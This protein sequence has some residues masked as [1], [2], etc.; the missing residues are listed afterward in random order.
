MEIEFVITPAGITEQPEAIA[1]TIL[2]QIGTDALLAVSAREI[3]PLE[4]GVAFQFGNRYGLKRYITVTY[5]PA[6]DDYEILATRIQRNGTVKQIAQYEGITWESL[7][8]LVRDI[9]N[10][11]EITRIL[12]REE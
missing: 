1:Q 5:R 7:G 12:R 3:T 11:A 2:E 6:S 10:E 9:N 8:W 4:S